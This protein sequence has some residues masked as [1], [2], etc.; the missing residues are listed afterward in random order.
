VSETDPAPSIGEQIFHSPV[1]IC[2]HKQT[3]HAGTNADGRCG[4]RS[5][6][7]GQYAP[8]SSGYYCDDPDCPGHATPA[9]FCEEISWT[10][11]PSDDPDWEPAE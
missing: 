6:W 2:G 4:N 5:C 1:C 9:A 8:A 7:C 10:G 11:A 3:L